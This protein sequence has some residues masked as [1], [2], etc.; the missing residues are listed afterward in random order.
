MLFRSWGI[1]D[2]ILYA[3]FVAKT[4]ITAVGATVSFG[5]TEDSGAFTSF[6]G[7]QAKGSKDGWISNGNIEQFVMDATRG[8]MKMEISGAPA[9]SGK[10][11]VAVAYVRT[12]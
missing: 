8:D 3:G 12:R 4:A 9:T 11:V 7:N 10:V 2:F 1:D 6:T 5:N